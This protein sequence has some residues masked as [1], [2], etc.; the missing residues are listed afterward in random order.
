[1]R[2]TSKLMPL[3][4][5]GV[6]CLAI[7]VPARAAARMDVRL[8]DPVTNAEIRWDFQ[9]KEDAF[10]FFLPSG[11]SMGNLRVSIP[12]GLA[13]ELDG[14]PLRDGDSAARFTIGEQHQLSDGRSNYMCMLMQSENIA[15]LFLTTKS[16][17]AAAI[18]R[19]KKNTETGT[20]VYRPPSGDP[21]ARG[22][23]EQI[24]GHGHSS[25]SLFPKKS[26]QIKLDQKVSL[27]GMP[28][29]KKWILIGNYRDR[30]LLRNKITLDMARA[31]GLLP[32][33]QS[34][35]VDLYLNGE[36][37]GNY[38]LTEKIEIGKGRVDIHDLEKAT[39]KVN[40]I[41]KLDGFPLIN[42]FAATSNAGKSKY[43]SIP[44]DP[45]DI[46]GGYL[47]EY[48]AYYSRYK[49]VSSAY[50]TRRKAVLVVKSPKF[51]SKAQMAY[52]S[53]LLQRLEDAIFAK[54]GIDPSSGKHY[55]ELAD[56]ESLV[57]RYLVE[58]ISKNYDGN[59]S[60]LYF[61]KPA[62]SQSSL[63]YAG[64]AWDYDSSYGSYAR[65]KGMAVL[66][67]AGFFISASTL[68]PHWWPALYRQPD[69]AAASARTYREVFAPLLDELLGRTSPVNLW[70][71]EQYKKH[72]E[73][74]AAMNFTRWPINNTKSR[75]Q[76][77]LANTHAGNV[78]ILADFITQRK[79][80]L[81]GAWA[82]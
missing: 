77:K 37:R 56:L 28:E 21:I 54:D 16:G 1:M 58:E 26:Y 2:R 14:Q 12:D 62:D 68:G 17:S 15:S 9:K 40:G 75:A 78:E 72:I 39:E 5:A 47:I 8:I 45:G 25:F 10:V 76:V 38:L 46:T 43:Y 82:E 70:S 53:D 63:L 35:F 42:K 24:K 65:R 57:R 22:F 49:E 55:T 11:L 51:T 6:L 7:P 73:A 20:Y 44:I 27:G 80:F 29:A 41:S 32:T 61:Y 64:P 60:S 52:I 18:H 3:I 23:L 74:S 81:D 59:T 79:L 33:S 31:A 66:K 19:S 34:V 50:A 67:P 69:F 48:E 71:L 36:Y 13:V 4:L 30:S